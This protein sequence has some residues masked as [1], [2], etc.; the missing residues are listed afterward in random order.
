MPTE[1]IAKVKKQGRY[2]VIY[3]DAR[4]RTRAMVALAVSARPVCPVLNT[5]AGS[6]AGG[7]LTAGTYYYRVSA[8]VGGIEGMAC[9]E[10]SGTVA[11]GTTGSVALTWA[12]VSG[13]TAYK[14]YGRTTG[15]EQLLTS[16]A[17][18]SYTDT[19]AATPSGAL[20]TLANA[21]ATLSPR[22]ANYGKGGLANVP[23]ATAMRGAS[24]RYFYRVGTP[25]GYTPAPRV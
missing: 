1:Q 18:T 19:G 25:A 14:I 20:P 9:A 16:Q 7:T 22:G 17:G 24:T 5:P 11:S 15:A 12:A 13:A 8:T 2:N 4:G 10:L 6:T 23:M 3:R 21:K